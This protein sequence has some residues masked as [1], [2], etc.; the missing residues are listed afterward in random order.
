M[1]ELSIHKNPILADVKRI[2]TLELEMTKFNNERSLTAKEHH[3]TVSQVGSTT[4]LMDLGMPESS[5]YNRVIGFGLSDLERLSDIVGIYEAVNIAP[6]FDMTPDMQHSRVAQALS[7]HGYV[8]Q[9]QL[10]YLQ[11]ELLN[12]KDQI[13]QVKESL[14]STL[15]IS[16]VSSQS[17]A[18]QFIDLVA[19]S[20]Q[21]MELTEKLIEQK[22]RY[23]Y[24]D[25]FQNFVAYIGQEPAA[26]ASLFIHGNNGYAANDFTFPAFRGKGCQTALICHR[27]STA[28]RLGLDRVFADVEFGT[29]SHANMLKA[30]FQNVFINT[31]W[32]KN[33]S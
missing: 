31:F 6:C 8:P 18:K 13:W 19:R 24:R 15:S 11:A 12:A 14:G 3:L 20:H 27:L 32:L 2:V 29:T 33:K 9:L 25:D 30:G 22:S 4:L 1:D 5:Y 23:Y 21:G 17:E 7:D 10:A 16:R 26:L 28:S